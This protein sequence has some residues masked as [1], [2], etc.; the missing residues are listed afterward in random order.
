MDVCVDFLDE[1]DIVLK[2]VGLYIGYGVGIDDGLWLVDI[3]MW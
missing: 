1:V 2:N 3:D